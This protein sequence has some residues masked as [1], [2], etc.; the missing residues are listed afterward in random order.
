MSVIPEDRV[1][2]IEEAIRAKV[3]TMTG[4]SDVEGKGRALEKAFR[5]FDTNG[6]GTVNYNEFFAA[7][8]RLNFVGVQ[9]ELE[10]LFDRYD[11]H[12]S[13]TLYYKDFCNH[14]F[15]MGQHLSMNSTSRSV[16]ARVKGSI[17]E[18]GGVNGLRSLK[19]FLR[20]MDRDGSG[21]LDRSELCIGL[22]DFGID[23]DDAPGGDVDKLIGF[24]DRDGN[25]RINLEEFHRGLQGNMVKGRKALVKEAFNRL[26]STGDGT[27]TLE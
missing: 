6:S 12:C 23:V 3:D 11:E 17:F 24:F 16:V 9:R 13:N 27:V 22:G 2:M 7:M 10:S 20:R 21:T 4:F 19:Y 15:G 5:Y 1:D 18:Q 14:L 8:T 25:N 26:D